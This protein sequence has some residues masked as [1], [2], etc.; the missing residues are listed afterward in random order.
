M[1]GQATSL[2]IM[3]MAAG[4]VAAAAVPG[5]GAVPADIAFFEK[6]VRPI[7]F[8]RCFR[9]H[10]VA[11]KK[12]KGGLWLDSRAAILKGGDTG[13]AIV[14]GD[15]DRSL[16]I[17]AVRYQK[18]HLQMPPSGKL[19]ASE[20][21]ALEEWVRRGAV[22]P[23]VEKVT[24]TKA[25][26]DLSEARKF[27]SFQPPRVMTPPAVTNTAWPR[28]RI[29]TFLLAAMEKKGLQPSRAASRRTL[30]RRVYFDLLGLPP[31]PEEVDAFLR[32][33]A[34]DA[35]EKLVERLLASP[36]YGER[37]GR[38]WLD[39]ARYCDVSES[40]YQQKGQ[41]YLY[42]DW[43]VRALNDDMPYD[44]FVQKQIAADLLP[45]AVPA[46]RAALG[47]IGLSPEYWKELMLD[48][49]VI[50]A[51][52]AEEWEERI[53]ALTGTF[54]GLTVACARCHDHKFDPV[55][56]H[57]YYALAGVFASMRAI[58]RPLVPDA[59]MGLVTQARQKV[60]ALDDEIAKLQVGKPA[61]PDKDARM[62]SL[63]AQI[64]KIK[65]ETP[66]YDAPTAAAVDDASLQV[67]ADGPHRTKLEYKPGVGQD[68]PMQVRGNPSAVGPIVPRR[69]LAV[70]SPGEP[71]PFGGSGRLDL[72]QA[73]VGEGTPLSSRVIVN[74]VWKH[75]FG[76]GLVETPSDFGAQGE[77][78]SHPELLDDLTARFIAR[79]WSLKWLHR[80][81][82]LSAAYQQVSTADAGARQAGSID[83]GNRLLW[84]MN[85]RRLE[86]EAWRDA[87]LA[88]SGVLRSD[89]GGAAQE[90][91]DVRNHR[92][93]LYATVKRRELSDMLRLYDAPDATVHSPA[94]V[95]TTTPLQQLFV[96]NSPFMKQQSAELLQRL[97]ADATGDHETRIRRAY[98]LLYS[99]P[100]TDVQV[101]Q[102]L[103]FLTAGSA[104]VTIADAAW[105]Q[106]LQVLLGSNEFLFVD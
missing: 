5:A 56:T 23:G 59:D 69:F 33:P 26:R 83:P 90:L 85:R 31:T 62:A 87:M 18:D 53:Q 10:S 15:A 80:E 100:A 71:K 43:V 21:V 105:E 44:R 1:R 75:H 16:L 57:D 41:P 42:R 77:R 67:L 98:L 35:F 38:Y 52:V 55:T 82:V 49:E 103:A 14:P 60:K 51:V 64:D 25:P 30:I 11:A 101:K 2:L 93:T 73:L 4:P 63:Q 27:W 89:V 17:Q 76:A 36:H 68:I 13:P 54:L 58:E 22:F 74:R 65:K 28:Q 102:A 84:R 9:C 99:R 95:P 94:R 79:G 7:L 50:K 34:A 97:K 78:P 24:E 61:P 6:K 92:R 32:D 46:D 104:G 81:I 88:A 19:P 37:W 20:I 106:Y 47:F 3:V 40:W 70:L 29:D 8:D 12:Q 86:V 72:A 45:G 66:N 39:L 91:T 96:L 48:K